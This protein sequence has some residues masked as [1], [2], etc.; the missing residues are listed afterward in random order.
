MAYPPNLSEAATR[1]YIDGKRLLDVKSY[2]NAGYHFGFA[3][4][5]V[6][7]HRLREAGVRDD[8][9]AIRKLHFEELRQAALLS[10][11]GRNDSQLYSILNN[12]NFMH[13]WHTRMRYSDNQSVSEVMAKKWQSQADTLMG[14]LI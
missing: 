2:N 12:N 9:P 6:T 14:L 7:K 4:E 11:G 5:C 8:D 13:A 10:L 3:A 1:H